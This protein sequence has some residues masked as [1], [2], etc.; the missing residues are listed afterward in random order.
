[1]CIEQDLVLVEEKAKLAIKPSD[2][3]H[4]HGLTWVDMGRRGCV[5][6]MVVAV[7]GCARLLYESHG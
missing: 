3:E 4:A 2:R 5:R 1:M 7:A 6:T